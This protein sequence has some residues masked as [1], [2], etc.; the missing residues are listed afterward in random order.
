MKQKFYHILWKTPVLLGVLSLLVF[1][2]ISAAAQ[3]GKSDSPA[4]FK[5]PEGK[6]SVRLE[7]LAAPEGVLTLNAAQQ[8]QALSLPASGADSLLKNAQGDLLVYIGV[9]NT[10][11]TVQQAL[12]KAGAQIVH[13]SDNYRTITAY[14]SPTKLSGIADLEFVQ[15]MEEVLTPYTSK[16]I[17]HE[18]NAKD[19]LP[20]PPE[21]A[22]CPGAVTTEG[23]GHLHADDARSQFGVDGSGVTVGVLSDSFAR[24]TSPKSQADDVASGDLPGAGNPCGHTTPVNNI[25]EYT[26]A[27]ATDEGR[28]MAQIVHDLAPGAN[29][30]FATAFNGSLSFADNIRALR[31]AGAQVIVDDVGYSSSPFFQDGPISNAVKD[32]TD[33][34]ALYFAAAGNSNKTDSSGNIIS[35]YEANAYRPTTCPTLYYN[36]SPA[37]IGSSCHDFNPGA[38]V[39]NAMGLSFGA[40]GQMKLTFQWAEPWYG[41]QTDFDIYV[42]DSAGN[43]LARG[44]NNNLS[45][46]KPYENFFYSTASSRTV[47]LVIARYAGSGTPPIKFIMPRTSN[48]QAMEYTAAN[49]SDIF[50]PTIYGQ[51]G[52]AETISV[53]AVP[54]YSNSTPEPFTS[55]GNRTYYYQRVD[56]TTPAA[57]FASPE[58]R[59]KPDIA[60]T[61]GGCNTF[62]G[63]YSGGCHRF[64]GTSAAAPHTAA[65]AA[66]MWE[67]ATQNSQTLTQSSARQTLKDTAA[68]LSNGGPTISGDGLINAQAA[69]GEVASLTPKLNASITV[70]P[71]P[72]QSTTSLVTYTIKLVNSG[73]VSATQVVISNTI[74]TQTTYLPGSASDGGS[75]SGGV[76]TWPPATLPGQ[77]N[78]AAASNQLIRTFVVSVTSPIT[79]GDTLTN[80]LSV[81]TAENVNISQQNFSELVDPKLVYLPVVMK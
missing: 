6:L 77:Q 46:Q 47:Y 54:Y 9:S 81:S 62:F 64:F 7:Q 40:S 10:T 23:D 31:T 38:G 56:G 36:G 2:A 26:G 49:S 73:A 16:D 80:K 17:G 27:G 21:Q 68:S 69:L 37:N 14:I 41:V 1:G 5:K 29:L 53:A 32:V 79:S 48:Y 50:G 65:V 34:G 60:A 61:D 51:P 25:A 19:A 28:G 66:L 72:V 44:Y 42:V 11:D 8:A 35:S 18:N 3:G 13:V 15:S 70:S 74:P 63:G 52:A 59:Q 45:L 22:G 67:W 55:H 33:A 20:R 75:E 76:I 57:P 30:A 71:Y 4:I 58:V 12:T 43:I 39:D 78:R 24:V